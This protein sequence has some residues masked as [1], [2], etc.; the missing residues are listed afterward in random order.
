MISKSSEAE[1]SR[2]VNPTS[3]AVCRSSHRVRAS[4]A[5]VFD[6]AAAVRFGRALATALAIPFIRDVEG[7]TDAVAL[8][9]HSARL[10]ILVTGGLPRR[11]WGVWATVNVDLELTEA[12]MSLVA[13]LARLIEVT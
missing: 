4:V 7:D 3:P 9:V 11:V 12:R 10:R 2:L 8:G 1:I 5:A 6:D 13:P